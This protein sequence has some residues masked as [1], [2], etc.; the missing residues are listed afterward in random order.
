MELFHTNGIKYEII[1]PSVKSYTLS[2]NSVSANLSMSE[3][4]KTEK[5]LNLNH[6]LNP[7]ICA[8][9]CQRETGDYCV[10]EDGN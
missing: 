3:H 4:N 5:N 2:A 8:Y 9:T 10:N 7:H 1:F 6:Y